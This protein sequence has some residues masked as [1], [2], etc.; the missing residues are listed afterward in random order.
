MCDNDFTTLLIIMMILSW[1]NDYQQMVKY[2]TTIT[3]LKICKVHDVS[4]LIFVK[5]PCLDKKLS[6]F[7]LQ[8]NFMCP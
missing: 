4:N 5:K 2:W 6:N 3:L 8:N 1:Y 7:K